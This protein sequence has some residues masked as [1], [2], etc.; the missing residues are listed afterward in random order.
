MI[1]TTNTS[2]ADVQSEFSGS[3]PISLGEYYLDGGGGYVLTGGYTTTLGV[4]PSSGPI[5]L[6]DFRGVSSVS[7]FTFNDV[8]TTDTANYDLEARALVGG[9]SGAGTLTATVTINPGVYVYSTS[10]LTPAFTIGALNVGSTVS[11]T[12]NGIIA[13]KGGAGGVGGDV[14]GAT[15]TAGSNGTVGG[16]AASFAYPVALNNTAGVIGGGGGGGGGGG[17][18]RNASNAKNIYGAGGGGGGGGRSRPTG[19]GGAGAAGASTGNTTNNVGG[20]GAIG[21]LTAPGV[22]GAR[23]DNVGV[24][25]SG[26]GGAGGNLG[27]PGSPG[28]L[29]DAGYG[30]KVPNTVSAPGAG[31]AAGAAITGGV[32]VTWT[33]TAFGAR[34]GAIDNPGTSSI[35]GTVRPGGA[36]IYNPGDDDLVQSSASITFRSNGL[37]SMTGIMS[38]GASDWWTTAPQP[39]IGNSYWIRLTVNSGT[40]G[41][42]SGTV[43]TWLALSADQTWTL[44]NA[45]LNTVRT[46]QT[47]IEIASDSGG[48]TIVATYT[49]VTFTATNN[50]L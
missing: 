25:A 30:G 49:S 45:V 43:N 40:G 22:G 16:K 33:G 46:R 38:S 19:G 50:N 9:W 11:I 35:S 27:H 8:V 42:F 39:A 15:L 23:Y 17:S 28:T 12:N 48:S 36:D 6:G 44:S 20:A 7:T 18:A 24:I 37:V 32:N 4:P 34:F 1:P 47:T 5:S 10:V 2:L 21:T 29:P 3:N 41:L 13:G 26:F 31:G 14:N